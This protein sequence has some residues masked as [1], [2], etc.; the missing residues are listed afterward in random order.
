LLPKRS[1]QKEVEH[2]RKHTCIS[3]TK[4]LY[5]TQTV[6]DSKGYH[7]LNEHYTVTLTMK[8]CVAHE[9]AMVCKQPS[10][11]AVHLGDF[12]QKWAKRTHINTLKKL[13]FHFKVSVLNIIVN[14]EC[15]SQFSTFIKDNAAV[16][17]IIGIIKIKGITNLIL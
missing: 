11:V 16:N 7:L 12:R 8:V 1:S 6:L 9:I 14:P 4:N 2:Q 15:L 5:V 17:W 10:T 13:R 3:F